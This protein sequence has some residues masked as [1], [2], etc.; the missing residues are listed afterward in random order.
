[1]NR[2]KKGRFFARR[3]SFNS[4][5]MGGWAV[6]LVSRRV[7]DSLNVG[8]RLLANDKGDTGCCKE[9]GEHYQR[10]PALISCITMWVETENI[11]SIQTASISPSHYF[12]SCRLILT[13]SSGGGEG[14]GN[15][16]RAKKRNLC[17]RL[18]PP[19]S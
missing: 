5:S 8:V 14:G 15:G 17:G 10:N 12:A 19:D 3:T 2:T 18:L 7:T 13:T 9:R 6:H 1:M 16:P 4:R 11:K